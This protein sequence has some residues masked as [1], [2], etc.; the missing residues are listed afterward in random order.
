MAGGAHPTHLVV[1]GFSL[2]RH[3]L[4]TRGP[5]SYTRTFLSNHSWAFGPTVRHEKWR[6][7]YLGVRYVFF[8]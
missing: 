2:P 4:D 5:V 1:A 8:Y 7:F 3:R 6:A